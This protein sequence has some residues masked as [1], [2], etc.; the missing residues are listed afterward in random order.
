MILALFGAAIA[1]GFTFLF[2]TVESLLPPDAWN[3]AIAIGAPLAF[4][5]PPIFAA[6][7]P[8]A[9]GAMFTIGGIK[10]VINLMGRK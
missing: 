1:A 2:D 10:L 6:S 8:L 5:V 9:I 7:V 3:S 4:L